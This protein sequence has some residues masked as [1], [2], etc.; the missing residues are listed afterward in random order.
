M[1]GAQNYNAKVIE[2]AQSNTAA[3][4]AFARELSGVKSP[5]EFFALSA[6]RS[7]QQFEELCRQAKVLSELAQ[8]ASAEST[9]RLQAGV[10]KALNQRV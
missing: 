1:K 10:S 7:R 8:N 4:F 5:S 2:F 6:E 3:A 9:E